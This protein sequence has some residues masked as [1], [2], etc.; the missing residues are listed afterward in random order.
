MVG[1]GLLRLIG[2]ARLRGQVALTMSGVSMT[3][4]DVLIVTALKSEYVAARDV[5]TVGTANDVGISSWD[6]KDLDTPTPYLLGN[7]RRPGGGDLLIALARPTRMGADSTA[8]VVSSLRGTTEANVSR[9]VRSVCGQSGRH[10]AWGRHCG[11][12]GIHLRRA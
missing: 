9:D 4:V 10:R 2:P 7:Y 3:H 5:G 1:P 8:P 6:E 11:R 12:D